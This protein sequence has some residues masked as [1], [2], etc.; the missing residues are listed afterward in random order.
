MDIPREQSVKSTTTVKESRK[1][2]KCRDGCRNDPASRQDGNEFA[3]SVMKNITETIQK[4]P[5]TKRHADM[6]EEGMVGK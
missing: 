1:S 3:E 2:T 4:P 6:S 5:S